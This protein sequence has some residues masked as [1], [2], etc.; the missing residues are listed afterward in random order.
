MPPKNNKS[1][2]KGSTATSSE[3]KQKEKV[4]K[5]TNAVPCCTT[6][7]IEITDDVRALQCDHCTSEDAWKCVDCM[8]LTKEVY[9]HVYKQVR[10]QV[11]LQ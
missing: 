9:D 2:S 11:V 6:C 3:T 4:G 8:E 10:T 1:V 5:S 7:G